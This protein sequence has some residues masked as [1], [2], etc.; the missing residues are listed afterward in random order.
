MELLRRELLALKWCEAVAHNGDG[1]TSLNELVD[2]EDRIAR[3]WPNYWQRNAHRILMRDVPL[4][5]SE[6]RPIPQCPTCLA[7]GGVQVSDAA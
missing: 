7:T 3:L 6:E 1:V 4:V 2:A 5:H